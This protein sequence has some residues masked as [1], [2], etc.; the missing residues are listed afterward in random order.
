MVT[1]RPRKEMP[2]RI[3]AGRSPRPLVPARELEPSRSHDR[4]FS[5]TQWKPGQSIGLPVTRLIRLGQDDPRRTFSR[6]PGIAT[7]T[8]LPCSVRLERPDDETA[9]K[10]I[11]DEAFGP[12]RYARS[13]YRLREH[14]PH[15]P[16]LS[17]VAETA[18]GLVGSVRLTPVAIANAPGFLLGPLVVAEA[19]QGRGCGKALVRTATDAALAGGASFVLLVGDEPYY[20]PLGYG[21]AD[22]VGAVKMPGPADPRRILLAVHAGGS[23]Q[24]SGTVRP[25]I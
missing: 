13:A 21:S 11:N 19:W 25:R 23:R 17:F 12:G 10:S 3:I 1:T 18:G 16:A 14:A 6:L 22:P 24:L 8:I 4:S 15:D 20:G 5:T 2:G 7:L 9:I